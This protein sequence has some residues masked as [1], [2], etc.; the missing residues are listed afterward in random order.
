MQDFDLKRFLIENK[1]TRNSQTSMTG[2]MP[3]FNEPTTTFDKPTPKSS[4]PPEPVVYDQE[5]YQ[6]D[7]PSLLDFVKKFVRDIEMDVTGHYHDTYP[8][9]YSVNDVSE[10]EG[11]VFIGGGKYAPTVAIL[12]HTPTQK[13]LE[14][15]GTN[16]DDWRLEFDRVHIPGTPKEGPMRQGVNYIK[17]N[18]YWHARVPD[19][20]ALQENKIQDFD[21]KR[22]LIE[23]KMTR[24][25]RLLN[26][27]LTYETLPAEVK[28]RYENN[29]RIGVAFIKKDGSVRH[30]S[31]SKTLKAYQ[32]STAAKTDA[33]SNYR[34]NNNLWSGYDVNAYI[35]AKKETGDDTAAAKQSFRNFKLENVLAFSAGGRVF[36]M[37]DENN[38]VERFGEDVAN[39]LTKSMIQ[40]LERDSASTTEPTTDETPLAEAQ[41]D[42]LITTDN[43]EEF[44]KYIPA[45]K[46]FV[47]EIDD[48]LSSFMDK[49]FPNWVDDDTAANEGYKQWKAGIKQS[50]LEMWGP[51][52]IVEFY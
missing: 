11:I 49:H 17:K 51:D 12:N 14:I 41:N 33:Q 25:S 7:E 20:P 45:E 35:K 48:S 2:D 13:D 36:D 15:T 27:D 44:G 4:T 18:Y 8:A 1:M 34:Q 3:Q 40:A 29:G 5:P 43:I 52:T 30:M 46:T 47:V 38:I 37:R 19:Q 22:F 23:N 28:Q 16:R 42:Q 26:E 9:Q 39:A 32:P 24:N 50:A 6:Y 31:F 21:L 10:Y